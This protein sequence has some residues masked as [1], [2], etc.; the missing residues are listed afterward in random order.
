[1]RRICHRHVIVRIDVMMVEVKC[2]LKIICYSILKLFAKI[3]DIVRAVLFFPARG[4]PLFKFPPAVGEQI[5]CI[6]PRE[7]RFVGAGN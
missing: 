2:D 3:E 5:G 7:D 1:M 6:S 4:H